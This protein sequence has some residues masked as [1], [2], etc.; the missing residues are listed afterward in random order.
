[1]V[2]GARR[3]LRLTILGA[4]GVLALAACGS[5]GG[6]NGPTKN[7]AGGYG[8][9]PAPTSKP[10]QGGVVTYAEPVGGGPTF[11]FPIEDEAH[12]TVA[13]GFQ[14]SDLMWR[15]LYWPTTGASPSVDY[16]RSLAEPP[17]FAD[18]NKTITIKLDKGYT[19]SDG[20]PVT[21]NDILFTI[22]LSKA[23]IKENP[24][25][26]GGYTPGEF[27]DNIVSATTPDPQTVVLKLDKTFNSAWLL[28]NEL[29]T[30]IEPLP[31]QAWN[32]AA[33]G[34]PHLDF[35]QPANAK[36]IY[37]FLFKQSQSP[38]TYATNPIWQTVD[39]PFKIKTYNAS[40]TGTTLVANRA[41][42][43]TQ[44]PHIDE[45]DELAYTS[46]NAEW[47]DVLSG[48][49][50]VGYVDFTDLPQL[51]RAVKNSPGYAYY[52]LP[53][54]GFEYLYFNFKDKTNN[55][56]KIVA[57]LY[58]RQALAHL[59]NEPAVIRGAF[60]NAAVPAYSTIASLPTSK[61]SKLAIT[62]AI[63]PYSISTAKQLMSSHGWTVQNGVLTCTSPGTG[64]KNCGA[65]IPRGQK[66]TFNIDYGNSPAAI[67]QQIVALASAAKQLGINI[68]LKSFTFNQLITIAD[69][70]NSPATENQ[71]A[72]ADF[73]GFTG[74]LYPTGDSIFNTTGSFDSGAYSNPKADQLIH[75]SV[76][77]TDPNAL[78][79]ES[80]FIGKDLPA[81]F[82]PEPDRIYI[83][84]KTLQGPADSFANLTQSY[85]TPE[86]WW[87]TKK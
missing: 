73:G 56:D 83:W 65:G 70:V 43:G 33:A 75:D 3:G 74:F 39:G 69:D 15:P 23:A 18:N 38:A 63:Y 20:K 29:A 46:T 54:T 16:S 41:Y 45:I 68:S 28:A 4:A 76:F 5:G 77:G 50:D 49:L 80:N 52:G 35:S 57:Q 1:M 71:W 47:N 13:N 21:G 32:I 59:Q 44:K 25:N 67:G 60:K 30:S 7:V 36:R 12:Q 64:P 55:F 84:K 58:F 14:F 40:T 81:I 87:L 2:N 9:I 82:Q 66:L 62:S 72:M 86:D 31:S 8:S 85:L 26:L 78:V 27:P 61:Y 17:T 48:Q 6:A 51:P 79:K 42:T 10:T 53:S 11:I 24:A 19:W 34:G 37:D 22:A